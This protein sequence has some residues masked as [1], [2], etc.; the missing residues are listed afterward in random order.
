MRTGSAGQ[1]GLITSAHALVGGGHTLDAVS[2]AIRYIAGYTPPPG[3]P[4]LAAT[5][6]ALLVDAHGGVL[7][8]LSTSPP[9]GACFLGG[10]CGGMG[11]LAQSCPL[12][13][14][15]CEAKAHGRTHTCMCVYV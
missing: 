8:N 3:T 11:T 6:T 9:L 13:Y 14:V 15:C 4:R 5:V 1:L 12:T 7:R 10:R 2:L